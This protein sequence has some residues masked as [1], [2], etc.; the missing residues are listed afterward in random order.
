MGI[1]IKLNQEKKTLRLV[2]QTSQLKLTQTGRKGSTGPTGPQ[3]YPGP[4]GPMGAT[5]AQGPLGYTGA[6]GPQGNVG[7]TGQTGATGVQGQTGANGATGAQGGQGQTGAQGFTGP[8]GAT[9]AQ[10]NQGFTGANGVQGFT[11]AQGPSGTVGATGATGAVGATGAA[12]S[13]PVTSVNGATGAVTVYGNEALLVAA[14]DATA[15]IKQSAAYVCDGTDDHVQIQQAINAVSTNGG[16]VQL[17]FG[18]FNLGSSIIINSSYINLTG[19][20]SGTK[21]VL[22][23]AVNDSIIKIT[24]DGV[25]EVKL[26]QMFLD[27]NSANNTSGSGIY[28][29]TKWV[30]ASGDTQHLVE[31]IY[32]KNIAQHGVHVP[33]SSD[34]RVLWF[35]RV[36]VKSVGGHGFFLEGPAPTDS[37]FYTCLAELAALDGFRVGGLN[38]HFY[39]CKSF[40]N[41]GAG[42]YVT[43][44]TNYFVSCESQDNFK[45][46][47]YIANTYGIVLT[48]CVA[49]AN[50]QSWVA[51]NEIGVRLVNT[52]SSQITGGLFFNRE[53][54]SYAQLKGI[55]VEGTS[56]GNTTVNIRGVGYSNND[57]QTYSDTSSGSN[58]SFFVNSLDN[59]YV[60]TGGSETISGLKTF[61]SG[62]VF[63]AM[64]T[65]SY[66]AGRLYY[67][68]AEDALT[69][70]G[71]SANTSLN[72]GQ[73]QYVR[74]QNNTG[75]T[76]TNGVPV[77]ISGVSG[78]VPT[79]TPAINTSAAAARAI[80]L[81]TE[82]IATGTSGWVA[83]QGKV[84]NV[85]TAAFTA[86]NTLYVSNAAGGLTATAPT[87]T[88]KSTRIGTV[89][90]SNATTG[91]ILVDVAQTP[92]YAASSATTDLGTVLSDTGLRTAGTAYP[93]T[94]SGAV[95]L[96]GAVALTGNN[97]Y[98]LATITAATTLTTSSV[99]HQMANATTAAF[100]V[101]LPAT[102]T[103]GYRFTIKKIDNSA[104]AVTILGTID[105]ATN[106]VLSA[107]WKYVTL[108]STTTSGTWYIIGNN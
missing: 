70:M 12:A 85:N 48:S 75:S 52:N 102:T 89:L 40:W 50:G 92:Q 61:S 51:Q 91:V 15:Q 7:Q 99:Q 30:N 44:Y 71:G 34:T 106:Y 16:T 103:A 65:P 79:V 81:T 27:G 2:G 32:V 6:T 36:H 21:L 31:D 45:E 84:R 35:N 68:S 56:T 22:Q 14:S 55:S 88:A 95:T 72:I 29:S 39:G 64:S 80:G 108:V 77:Y 24:G 73:E 98:G 33:G 104:N 4:T 78:G 46:G 57:T 93:I 63:S 58:K 107:Q 82:S 38:N 37:V 83:V 53:W 69:F 25:V 1:R 67:D 13:N 5:G 62:Q 86:G 101:T 100:N 23:N 41:T 59:E 105:G 3:G 11:G 97:R 49:D 8:V 66:S 94:S 42:Y 10:G 96:S 26:R 76:I 9:G 18:T 20:G 74:V 60:H 87:A 43:G 28:I 17:S 54:S 47:F 90:V 19:Q